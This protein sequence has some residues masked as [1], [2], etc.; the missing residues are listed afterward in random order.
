MIEGPRV[1]DSS[2]LL[3]AGV[4]L[5]APRLI[6]YAQSP[7]LQRWIQQELQGLRCVPYFTTSLRAAFEA[8]GEEV[9]RRVLIVDYDALTKEELVELRALRKRFQSGTFIALGEVREHLRAPLRVTHVLERPLG[10]EALRVLV[11]E[12]ENQ[13]DTAEIF[14]LPPLP[15]P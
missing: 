14:K 9:R 3:V 13:R 10:S 11:D 7:S 5:F 6:T 4:E 15:S 12:L 8:L 1:R 2:P